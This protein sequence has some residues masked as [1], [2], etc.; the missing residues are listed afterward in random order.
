M[1]DF[2]NAR[3]GSIGCDEISLI[4]FFLSNEA[5]EVRFG[6]FEVFFDSEISL[7][8]PNMNYIDPLQMIPFSTG[9]VI[10]PDFKSSPLDCS[11][12]SLI[13]GS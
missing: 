3:V 12:E 2:E 8:M 9:A 4:V 10:I 7:L 11:C 1:I 6:F 13:D 5:I